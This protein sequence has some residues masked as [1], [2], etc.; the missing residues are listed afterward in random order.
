MSIIKRSKDIDFA[1]FE[2][3]RPPMYTAMK[4]WGKKPNNIWNEYIS[5]YTPK[6]GIY[7]DPF[8][9]SAM[10]G[11]EAVIEGRK[12]IAL[13]INPLT[14]FLIEVFTSHFDDKLFTEKVNIILLKIKKSDIYR[15]LYEYRDDQ[16]VHNVK[17]E[18]GKPYEVALI[19]KDGSRVCTKP[20][21]ID[22][23]CIQESLKMKIETPYPLRKFHSSISFSNN[24][25]DKVGKSF[26]DL[27]T[28]RNLGVLSL[29]FDEILQEK[30]DN[31][32]KQLLF[33]FIKS[34]HL[35]TKMCV[36][37]GKKSNRDFSTSWGRSAYLY[38]KKQMEMNP[39]LL[40][41]S[42]AFGKQS[43]QKALEDF[44]NRLKRKIN[45][46]KIANKRD[47]SDFF[48]SN[49]DVD[50][51][52]GVFDIKKMANYIPAKSVD[53]ILTDP[54]YGGLIQYLDLSSIWLAW[55]EIYNLAYSPNYENEITINNVKSNYDFE[56][57]MTIALENI[58]KVLSDQGKV[59][60]TFNNKDLLTWKSLLKAIE[61][62]GLKIEK[63]I[64]QQNKRTGESNVSDPFGSSA[65]DFYIRCVK[66]E[67]KYLKEISASELDKLMLDITKDIIEN[68]AEPTPY[69]I[70]FNG[71]L[72]NMSLFDIDYKDI[73]SDFNTF[74]K[75]Y[76]GL[77]FTTSI[78]LK[79][80][81]GNYWWIKN[82]DYNIND[83]STLTKRV[84]TFIIG[85]FTNNDKVL[86]NTLF[87]F[88]YK[89]FP[90][91]LTPDPISLNDII[92]KNAIKKGNYWI[93]KDTING[94]G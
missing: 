19:L 61:S 54:P 85:I 86:E 21:D 75:R 27:Y 80:K 74:L 88:V 38:S 91:G 15:K 47:I 87:E 49:N 46:R 63:V 93:R 64:H 5:T 16:I 45:V 14:S 79:N 69:Q 92:T 50:L 43:T 68:R 22:I 56:K 55:L 17:Y 28:N 10:S 72:A 9:G 2:K 34:V 94:R 11:F 40:F 44:N 23:K 48:D 32:K 66:S 37:R 84:E 20:D 89:K 30:N 90:N 81:A 31:I 24:F 25:L 18:N 76:E 13:D 42:S 26:S 29:I 41:E 39:L 33:T 6:N 1:L 52:Y 65:S 53:F 57:D 62:S 82:K 78:N 8:S 67:G 36:P 71:V 70:L 4:Y 12:A 73:D 59:V 3:S 51:L 7:L 58:R 35:T 83:K 77:I 60:L